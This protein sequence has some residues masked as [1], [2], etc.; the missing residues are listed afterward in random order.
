MRVICAGF[1]R[2]GTSSLKGALE[3][4]LGAPC[5]HFEELFKHRDQRQ[6]W[7]RFARGDAQM[8]WKTLYEGYEATVDFPT[9]AYYLE[10]AELYPD[11]LILLSTRESESWANSW[12]SLWKYLR[13]FSNPALTTLFPWVRE[14]VDVLHLIL[15]DKVFGGDMSREHIIETFEKHN[16]S[17]KAVIP[18]ERLLV[19]RV[20]DGWEPL[21]E[22]LGVPVP[23]EPFPRY[24]PGTAPLIKRTLRKMFGGRWRSLT[25]G[26]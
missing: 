6:A 3:Q 22:A 16:E 8:D 5:Y 7:A 13:Y 1:G 10:L 2:T 9:C 14:I 23:D 11:A 4:L 24:N 25:E 17:V 15:R 18:K 26:A 20:Q 19:Y 12:E 21:C